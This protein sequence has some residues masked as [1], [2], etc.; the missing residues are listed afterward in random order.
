MG[1]RIFILSGASGDY[2]S[3]EEKRIGIGHSMQDVKTQFIEYVRREQ[4]H[5]WDVFDVDTLET[6]TKT[7]PWNF[8][9]LLPPAPPEDPRT[10]ERL[11][12]YREELLRRA[13]PWSMN[14]FPTIARG[15]VRAGKGK[16]VE[17]KRMGDP[18]S[19]E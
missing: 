12:W 19:S 9:H 18:D 14:A 1:K 3:Y 17:W 2:E 13:F 7:M 4:D 6:W 16:V 11:K 5:P 10:T 15:T 8:R